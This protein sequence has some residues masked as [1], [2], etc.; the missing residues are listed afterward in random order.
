[1]L[2]VCMAELQQSFNYTGRLSST[3]H[4]EWGVFMQSW[5]TSAHVPQTRLLPAE[6]V[7]LQMLIAC[8]RTKKRRLVQMSRSDLRSQRASRP[9][10]PIRQHTR[11][12]AQPALRTPARQA[13][14]VFS[15][16]Q[17]FHT[18]RPAHQ[19][20]MCSLLLTAA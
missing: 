19:M 6:L 7:A 16:R 2:V 11:T 15:S 17:T 4:V 20:T 13:A 12:S 3:Y 1:M 18:T 5:R 14:A 9:H 8:S 10:E